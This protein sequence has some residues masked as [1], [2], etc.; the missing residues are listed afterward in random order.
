MLPICFRKFAT[1]KVTSLKIN[2][3]LVEPS[4][5][6]PQRSKCLVKRELISEVKA[7]SE[8]AMDFAGSIKTNGKTAIA[9]IGTMLSMVNFSNLCINMDT[10]ITAI[11]SNDEPQSILCQILLR[12]V[13]IINNPDWVHLLENVASMTLLHWY[14]YSFLE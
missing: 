10:I 6:L 9:R 11:C 5:F 4:A 14:W 2:A 12:F 7:T 3:N 1:E 8:N 13:A